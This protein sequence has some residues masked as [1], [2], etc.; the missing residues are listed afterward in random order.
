MLELNLIK[1]AEALETIK[2]Q[3]ADPDSVARKTPA[4]ANKSLSQEER[5]KVL[6]HLK[7]YKV[8]LE[9]QKTFINAQLEAHK[10]HK[11]E[12][13]EEEKKADDNKKK[14]EEEKKADDNNVKG[15]KLSFEEKFRQNPPNAQERVELENM[16]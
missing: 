2:V 10:A 4:D 1:I 12:K 14:K 6:K 13:T 7:D 3:E 16:I 9:E 5:D 11:K 8:S 15:Y